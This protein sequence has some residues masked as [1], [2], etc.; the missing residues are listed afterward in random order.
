MG[1]LFIECGSGDHEIR[2]VRTLT[3]CSLKV[4]DHASF[5]CAARAATR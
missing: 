2:A 3:W 5:A 1:W 4:I